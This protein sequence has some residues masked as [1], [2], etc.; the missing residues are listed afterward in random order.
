MPKGSR[1][2]TGE[3]IEK[4]HQK[5]GN[6]YTYGNTKYVNNETPVLITC[7]KHGDFEQRAGHHLEGRGCRKCTWHP[8]GMLA[9]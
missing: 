3:F 8:Y 4:S 5:H 2:T 7:S 6:K 1:L 9:L